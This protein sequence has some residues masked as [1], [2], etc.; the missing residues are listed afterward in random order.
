[1]MTSTTQ[2][3]SEKSDFTYLNRHLESRSLEDVL[4]W[5][6]LTFGD[7]VAQV[8]SFGAAGMVVLDH[9]AR[10]S[11]GMRVITV[12][13]GFLFK[14][15]YDLIEQVQ[16]RYPIRLEIHRPTVTPEEQARLYGPQL[17]SVNADAC[18]QLRKV[19][20]LE[21]ALQDLD[22]WITGLR[23]DQASTRNKTPLVG[24]DNKYDMVKINP[25][26]N[27]SRN[28]VWSYVVEN[29]VPYNSLHDQGYGSIGCTHCTLPATNPNDERS[30]RWRGQQKVECGIHLQLKPTLSLQS[31]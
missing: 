9:L 3:F 2:L 5:S 19:V 16:A 13:T 15:S 31:C 10:L 8:S 4:M 1:M 30:G 28:D 14:E 17:W 24:W 18:C 27:W 20:P 21:N 6:L 26:A 11:P 7:K 23:R 29:K 12:D 22:A 25:M